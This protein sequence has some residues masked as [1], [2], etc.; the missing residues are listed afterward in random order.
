MNNAYYSYNSQM[1]NE[2][3]RDR[4]TG[5]ACDSYSN[6]PTGSNFTKRWHF[7]D[8]LYIVYSCRGICLAVL[9][10]KYNVDVTF[11]SSGAIVAAV[12]DDFRSVVF[13]R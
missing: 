4:G 8:M 5:H 6:R 2:A 9:Y 12:C 3:Y 7:T 13:S 10:R 11:C 1:T